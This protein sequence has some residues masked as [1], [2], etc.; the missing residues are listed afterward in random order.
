MP[1]F[2]AGALNIMLNQEMI[3]NNITPLYPAYILNSHNIPFSPVIRQAAN[4]LFVA[5]TIISCHYNK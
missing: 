2:S 4:S 5:D 3:Q 1:G